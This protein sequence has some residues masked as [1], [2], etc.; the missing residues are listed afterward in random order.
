LAACPGATVAVDEEDGAREKSCPVPESGTVCGLLLALSVTDKTPSL[1]PL[2]V[3]SKNTPIEQ[4]APG[5]T[6]FPQELSGA[7][8]EGLAVT[9]VIVS[10]ASPVFFSVTVCGKPEVPTYWFGKVTVGG[11]KLIPVM[12]TPVKGAVCGLPGALS[13]A[14]SEALAFPTAVGVK[15]TRIPQLALDGSGNWQLFPFWANS[16]LFAPLMPIDATVRV[17]TPVLMIVINRGLLLAPTVWLPK[18]RLVGENVTAGNTPTPLSRIDCGLPGA[19]SETLTAALRFPVAAGV[20]VTLM[21]Q[22][23]Y[24][25]IDEGQ[26]LVWPKS[27]L[28][29][30]EIW[31]DVMVSGR[32]PLLVRVA[33]NGLLLMPTVWLPKL[34][35]VG[36]NATNGSL[37]TSNTTP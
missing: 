31:M 17:P 8:S 4:V 23:L 26:L 15:V 9:F 28:F 5:T 14:V 33:A 25:G 35:L 12:P 10:T 27:L 22:L 24:G 19:L 20:N 18:L 6:L 3:G 34:R 37:L 11:E 7:K 16:L 13:V 21:L 29:G 32:L 2:V 36:E 30:P 1:V